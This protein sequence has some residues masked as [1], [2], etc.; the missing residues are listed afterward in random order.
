MKLSISTLSDKSGWAQAGISIPNFDVLEMQKKTKEAPV[1]VHFGAGNFFRGFIA[2]LAHNLLETGDMDRGIVAVS[3]YNRDI[4]SRIY[5]PYDNLILRVSLGAKGTLM[6]EVLGSIAEAL[7]L[8]QE[9]LTGRTRLHEIFKNP[10]L[11]IASLTITEKGYALRDPSGEWLPSVAQDME[12]GPGKTSHA[13]G[14]LAELLYSRYLAGAYPLAVVSMDNCSQNGTLLKNAVYE[15]AK[16]WE[17]AKHVDD[18]FLTYLDD[19]S[20]VAFPWT[21]VD[22]IAPRPDETIEADL[23]RRGIEDMETIVTSKNTYIAPFVNVEDSEYLVIEDKFPA[24]RPAL[25][26]TG[27]YFVDRDTVGKMERMKVTT[28][29]NPLHT[30]MSMYGCL[31]GYTRISAEM[32]DK[33]IVALIRRLGYVEG[34]PVVDNPIV[35]SPKEFL[36][37]VINERFP[38]PFMPDA[39]QRIATDTSQKVG[40]RFGETIKRYVEQGLDMNSLIAIPL[41]IAGWLRYL[42]A[43]DDEGNEIE[44][45]SDPLL[46]ELQEKVRSIVWNDPSSYNGQIR[47]I[48]SNKLIFG[49]DLTETPLADKIEAIFVELLAGKGAVR[50]TLQRY[51]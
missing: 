18:G 43:V 33:D 49:I 12:N 51:L 14:I 22:K 11:Q 21:M 2:A 5:E 50:A 39:P 27:V 45:S 48:L 6:P 26:K 16:T 19:E 31:L 15:I 36:D 3:T 13:M 40:I 37:T 1:W 9:E 20:K 44:V 46:A 30:A 32:K 41:S 8:E 10:G 4:V 42:L 34:L 25:E 29:L 23:K 7:V 28:C 35:I 47:E 17:N 38:N 24:G